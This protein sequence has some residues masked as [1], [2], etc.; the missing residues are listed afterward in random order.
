MHDSAVRYLSHDGPMI[1]SRRSASHPLVRR[2]VLLTCGYLIVTAAL[3]GALG[4]RLPNGL[5][6]AG[7]HIVG[8]GLLLA[9][10]RY[11]SAARGLGVLRDWHPLLLFPVLYK[12]VERLA[13]AFGDWRLTSV[14]PAIEGRLFGG[15]PSLSLSASLSFVPLSEWLHFCYLSHVI[16]I[17]AVAAYW[18]VSDRRGAFHELVLLLATVMFGSYLFFMLYPVDSPYYLMPRLGTPHAG[19]FFFDLVHAISDR[20]GARGGAFPSAHVSGSVVLW[21]VVWRHQ[22]R[23][24]LALAPVVIGLILATVYGRFHYALDA[25]AGLAVG[26]T[27]V[28]VATWADIGRRRVTA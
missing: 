25:F 2:T 16:M 1:G 15:Q 10:D 28:V 14:V 18:Y 20:G 17:P 4:E 6:L 9:V 7:A 5:W 19:H 26:A 13:A 3:I 24:A 12:E 27:V 23:L 22:R 11:A 21:L 8:A